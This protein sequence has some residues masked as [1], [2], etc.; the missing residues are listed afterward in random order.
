MNDPRDETTWYFTGLA[1]ANLLRRCW[2]Q[3]S[4]EIRRR[5][6]VYSAVAA[7]RFKGLRPSR[8]ELAQASLALG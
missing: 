4:R 8:R 5:R 6:R 7:V 1:A 3:P 2:Y